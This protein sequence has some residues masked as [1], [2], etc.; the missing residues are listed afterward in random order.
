M[1]LEDALLPFSQPGVSE[2]EAPHNSSQRHHQEAHG[3][4]KQHQ[5]L[6]QTVL[7]GA[8]FY[9]NCSSTDIPFH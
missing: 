3:R 6:K 1:A 9:F 8:A 7:R 2:V 4:N 5:E